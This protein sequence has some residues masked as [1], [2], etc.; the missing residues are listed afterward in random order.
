M[1]DWMG[2]ARE[3]H[4]KEGQMMAAETRNRS[5]ARCR[6]IYIKETPVVLNFWALRSTPINIT[7]IPKAPEAPFTAPEKSLR[8]LIIR[9]HNKTPAL[10]HQPIWG[11][12]NKLHYQFIR[13]VDD[14]T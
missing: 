9:K 8:Q 5:T 1:V 2:A 14:E 11:A 6:C 12:S 4:L 7:Q 3:P 13:G 10:S